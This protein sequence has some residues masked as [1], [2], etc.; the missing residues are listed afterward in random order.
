MSE[1]NPFTEFLINKSGKDLVLSCSFEDK[2]KPPIYSAH[3]VLLRPEELCPKRCPW[4]PQG[5]EFVYSID[6]CVVAK[7][8][9]VDR[10]P[11]RCVFCKD[12]VAGFGNNP[13]PVNT[14]RGARCCD[15]CNLTIVIPERIRLDH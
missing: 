14:E 8:E 15:N 13:D 5:A 10:W 9:D 11:I 3:R 7:N 2:R 6:Q 4:C 12:T 1:N